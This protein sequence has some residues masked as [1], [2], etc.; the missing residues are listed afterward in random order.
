MFEIC[1]ATMMMI[2]TDQHSSKKFNFSSRKSFR[3]TDGPRDG[4]DDVWP[5]SDDRRRVRTITVTPQPGEMRQ[6]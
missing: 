2:R 1:N 5:G 3:R 4:V 6:S